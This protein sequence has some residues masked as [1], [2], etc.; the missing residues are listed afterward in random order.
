MSPSARSLVVRVAKHFTT[1]HPTTLIFASRIQLHSP[2]ANDP[3]LRKTQT[4]LLPKNLGGR[5]KQVSLQSQ[6]QRQLLPLVLAGKRIPF[7]SLQTLFPV[8]RKTLLTCTDSTGHKFAP[9]LAATTEFKTGTIF[10]CPRSAP[11][12][13]ANN[14]AASFLIRRLCL[15]STSP[16]VLSSATLKRGL[17][18]TTTPLR[19]TTWC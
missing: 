4:R 7:S 14:S 12:L 2:L 9:D 1:V 19:T 11:L 18:S 6:S 16:L 15:K 10:A 3:P 8:V 17:Y 13:S 5:T